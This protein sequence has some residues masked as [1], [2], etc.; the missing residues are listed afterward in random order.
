LAGALGVLDPRRQQIGLDLELVKAP[1]SVA[2]G[3]QLK[4][5]T[6]PV[7]RISIAMR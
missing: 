5:L 6:V 7:S 1:R 3:E 4:T 2:N